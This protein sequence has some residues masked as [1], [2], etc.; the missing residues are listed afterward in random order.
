VIRKQDEFIEINQFRFPFKALEELT[1]LF[2]DKKL[3]HPNDHLRRIIAYHKCFKNFVEKQGEGSMNSKLAARAAGW[4][5]G[6]RLNPRQADSGFGRQ[7]PEPTERLHIAGHEELPAPWHPPAA[8]REGPL[9][10]HHR[11]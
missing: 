2:F 7:L 8:S 5:R 9:R 3:F 11:R 10:P 4:G 6:L 1:E